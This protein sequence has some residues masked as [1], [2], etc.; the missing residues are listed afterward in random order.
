M[1]PRP[2][3]TLALSAATVVAGA[4]VVLLLAAPGGAQSTIEEVTFRYGP[5]AIG[6]YD[7][8]AGGT[9]VRAP[10]IDG[11]IVR[12]DAVVVDR[13]GK[14]IPQNVVMLHHLVFK[15]LGYPGHVKYD[16]ACPG[17]APQ[18]RT[19]NQRFYGE[20]EELRALTMPKGYGYRIDRRDN[21]RMGWMLMNH[22]NR[23]RL[24]W[25]RYR[26]KID[27][28][29]LRPVTPYWF[30]VM[31]CHVDPQFTVPGGGAGPGS[32]RT[33]AR[34][35]TVPRDGRIVAVGGHLHGGSR[36]ISLT[37]PRCRN[38]TL[39]RSRP[40][41]GKP[42]DPLY[43]VKPLLHEPDPKNVSWWQS[44]TGV[45]VRKGETLRV[46]A[47]Y[48][49]DLPYMRVMGI[50]H[51]YIAHGRTAGGCPE[52]PSDADELGPDFAG[53]ASPP[54]TPLTLAEMG[55]RGT[56]VFAG[57]GAVEERGWAFTPKRVSVPVGA[58]IR[59]RFK[60]RDLH[61]ATL[62]TGPRGFSSPPRYGGAYS[63]RFTV[64]GT[65]RIYCSLH[66]IAM[67]QVVTVR[68]GH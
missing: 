21:W 38:R 33:R 48:R 55:S 36:D 51:V 14:A 8:R 27:T 43:R 10:R 25:I 61:D 42:G 40:T 60:D 62:L 30:S 16:G 64:P 58:P 63:H 37:Q 65:Y 44:S 12:M 47:R 39:V 31:G 1:I 15:N 56:R 23:T 6:R 54:H 59:W 57:A 35:F 26:V 24:G 18:T 17:K 11:S 50:D 28:R 4:L 68:G 5:I 53:R 2:A 67:Q 41:Y 20:S 19:G 34:G 9:P 29:R 13:D 45:P 66:P 46:A 32:T 49:A 22:T 7:G 52:M 3:L